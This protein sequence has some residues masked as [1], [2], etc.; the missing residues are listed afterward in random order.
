MSTPW[1]INR[2]LGAAQPKDCGAPRIG[3][4]LPRAWSALQ[5]DVLSITCNGL[6]NKGISETNIENCVSSHTATGISKT[7]DLVTSLEPVPLLFRARGTT[8]ES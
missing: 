5:T 2:N 1:R 8:R 7:P 3:A 6:C 4:A